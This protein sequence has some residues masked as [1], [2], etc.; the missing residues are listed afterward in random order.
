MDM[1]TSYCARARPLM[2]LIVLC[3]LLATVA[4]FYIVEPSVM[5]LPHKRSAMNL[6]MMQLYRICDWDKNGV[7][8]TSELPCVQKV[9]YILVTGR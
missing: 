1:Q 3:G 6:A 2:M 4:G 5:L 7:F 8:T 9:I